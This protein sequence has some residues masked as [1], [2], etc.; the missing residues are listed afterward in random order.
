MGMRR[1]FPRIFP[2]VFAAWLLL[3]P[4]SN[5]SQEQQK[6]KKKEKPVRK[7]VLNF[8]GGIVFETDGSLSE[9]TCFRLTGRV[10]APHFFDSF[11]RIDD[12]DGT[13]YWSGQTMVSEFPVELHV[14]F[15]MFDMPCASQMQQPGPRRYL[16]MEMMKSLRFMFYW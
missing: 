16:T 14:S 6:S 11:K 10:T 15:V 5:A 2:A 4:G 3:V 7:D 9:L 1:L 13:E 12:E 8:D